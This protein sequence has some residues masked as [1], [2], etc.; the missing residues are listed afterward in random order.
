MCFYKDPDFSRIFLYSAF[1][2]ELSKLFNKS[3]V[4]S[5][6]YQ[7]W[8]YNQLLFLDNNGHEIAIEE[9]RLIFEPI[10]PTDTELFSIRSKFEGNPRIVFYSYLDPEDGELIFLIHPFLEKN[11]AA[12]YKHAKEISLER[13]YFIIRELEELKNGN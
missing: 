6:E 9:Q 2:K 4:M 10:L 3:K 8:L 11:T 7:L 5:K 12:D 1:E 13:K